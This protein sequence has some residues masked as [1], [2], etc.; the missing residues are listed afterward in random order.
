MFLRLKDKGNEA[1]V[2]LKLFLPAGSVQK[3]ALHS[4]LTSKKAPVIPT[5]GRDL[6]NLITNYLKMFSLVPKGGISL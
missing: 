1:R 5:E 4:P 6:I 2:L 3:R